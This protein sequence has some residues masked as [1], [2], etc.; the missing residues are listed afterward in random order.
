MAAGFQALPFSE[1]ATGLIYTRNRWYDPRTGSFLTPDPIGYD[2][3]SSNLYAFCAGD[4]VN[5]SDP[6]GLRAMTAEDKQRLA[7]LKARGKKLYE[8]FTST[9]RGSFMQPMRVPVARKWYDTSGVPG[10]DYETQLVSATVMASE[11][12]ELA[13]R[14]MVN[15]IATFEA[16]VARADADGEILY[17]PG[18]GFTTI[19]AGDQRRADRSTMIAAG[20]FFATDALPMTLSPIAMRGRVSAEPVGRL[21]TPAGFSAEVPV[22]IPVEEEWRLPHG[23]RLDAGGPHDVYAIVDATTGQVYHFG[24]TGRGWKTRGAEW[25]RKLRNEYGLE[26]E[27]VP[28]R[29]GMPGKAAA[30]QLETRYITTYQK[31]FGRRPFYINEAGE[32]ITIQKTRH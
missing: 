10:G 5:C 27:V 2:G 19:T 9:G 15:D 3:G 13:K 31:A 30:K 1:P 18:Q 32:V 21:R 24:E 23:N 28:L 20:I 25:Q 12:Y 22:R 26:T 6:D 7:M 17:V 4:P 11:Y 14:T 8:D 16:A 29:T